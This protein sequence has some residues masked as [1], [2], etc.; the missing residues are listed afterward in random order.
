LYGGFDRRSRS[1]VNNL[2]L[3]V[4]WG[5]SGGQIDV[6]GQRVAGNGV[7]QGGNFNISNDAPF[8]GYPAI[9]WGAPNQFLVTWDNDDGNI[10][11]RRVDPATGAL[12]G[13]TILVTAGG[14]K[15]RS[16]IAY[17]S[18][19]SRWLVQFNNGAN[20]GFS[21]DQYG[22]L[23]NRMGPERRI[24]AVGAYAGI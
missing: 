13:S 8:S 6:F 9:A 7:L 11:G 10:Y 24:V 3:V 20:A 18:V 21:Y 1:P 22:Q 19:N 2:Y 12:Q 16:C 17:D 5:N 15:D 4:Y 23:V 14:G